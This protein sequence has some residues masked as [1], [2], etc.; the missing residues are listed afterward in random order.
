[1][2]DFYFAKGGTLPE[3]APSYIQRQADTDLYEAL[4]QAEYCYV[5]TS[6]QMGKSSLMVRVAERLRLDGAAVVV[7]EMTGIGTNLNVEQWYNG[8]LNKIGRNLGLNRQLRKFWQENKELGTLQRWIQAIRSVVLADSQQPLVICLDEIDVVL[9]LPFSTDEFFAGIRECYNNRTQDS[10]LQRL[11]F[12]L[13]GVATPSD[14]IADPQITPFNIGKRIDL[15]DF[16]EAEAA[17]FGQGLR[18]DKLL[19]RILYWT[20]GHP[21]LTQ[22]LC[23]LMVDDEMVVDKLCEEVFFSSRSRDAENNLQHVRSQVLDER[24]DTA[25]VLDL[26]RQVRS[27]KRVRDDDTNDLINTLRLAGL[28]HVK[29]NCLQVRN[30]IYSQVFDKVWIDGNMPDAEKRRQKSAFR[31]GLIQAGAVA[32]VLVGIA[33]YANEQRIV[34]EEQSK[35][36]QIQQ[37]LAEDE[38]QRSKQER[39]NSQLKAMS[40]TA[41]AMFDAHLEIEALIEIIK[42]GQQLK[43]K[44]LLGKI[45]SDTQITVATTLQKILYQIKQ[46]NRLEGHYGEITRLSFSPDGKYIVTSAVEGLSKGW[47]L[48]KIDGSL[49]RTLWPNT[50]SGGKSV[51][52]S[53]DG[54]IIALAGN[55]YVE[56]QT[57]D[58][59]LISLLDDGNPLIYDVE[60]SSDGKFLASTGGDIKIWRLADNKLIQ[61]LDF[62]ATD[63]V[64]SPN[65]RLFGASGGD[66][67]QIWSVENDTFK[68]IKKLV[69]KEYTEDDNWWSAIDISPDNQKF[70]SYNDPTS[71]KLWDN[72][73][74]LLKTFPKI[75][76]K[77]WTLDFSVDGQKIAAACSNNAL[78]K[79]FNLDG[80]VIDTLVGHRGTL[81]NAI[82]SPDG[83]F[84]AT[85]GFDATII[86]W[87]LN[88]SQLSKVEKNIPHETSTD[89][90]EI[91]LEE[92]IDADNYF[93]ENKQEIF[94]S[95]TNKIKVIV[96]YPRIVK[97]LSKDDKLIST[98]KGHFGHKEKSFNSFYPTDTGIDNVSFSPDEK[99]IISSSRGDTKLWK[100]DGTL[101]DSIQ[102]DNASFLPDGS[103]LSITID[104]KEVIWS[105]DID[106]LTKDG[107]EW[108]NNYLA[109]HPQELKSLKVCQNPS[110]LTRAAK[111]LAKEG[112]V[113]DAKNFFL[114]AIELNPELDIN[115]NYELRKL[116]IPV[117][118]E[119]ID[120]LQTENKIEK[121][122][123]KFQKIAELLNAKHTF[124][125]EED[126]YTNVAHLYENI[127]DTEKAEEMYA[128]SANNYN[129]IGSSLYMDNKYEQAMNAYEK[130]LNIFKSLKHNELISVVLGN[131][132]IVFRQL[133]NFQEAEK[134]YLGSIEILG[135]S[136]DKKSLA[137]NY[138]RL[139]NL[140]F[141]YEKLQQAENSYLQSAKLYESLDNKNEN[142]KESITDIYWSLGDLHLSIGNIQEAINFYHKSIKSTEKRY[143]IIDNIADKYIELGVIYYDVGDFNQAEQLYSK[144]LEIYKEGENKE[145]MA[146]VYN[147]LGMTYMAL[148]LQKEAENAYKS[149]IEF[150]EEL[151]K[152]G[153]TDELCKQGMAQ[154]YHNFGT[155]YSL[156]NNFLLAEKMYLRSIEINQEISNKSGIAETY[157]NLG[158][159]YSNYGNLQL[160]YIM[161]EKSIELWIESGNLDRSI[162]MQN[163]LNELK[164][165]E[166]Y[167]DLGNPSSTFTQ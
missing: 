147:E 10:D 6:R 7:L 24:K 12:C 38:S 140:Y 73:G 114:K 62:F 135:D 142:D 59:N 152:E 78:V 22:K 2:K 95:P 151:K 149:S 97:L 138:E 108:L 56:L 148:N 64:F 122:V 34:A 91:K 46:Y 26:Y 115:P 33:F 120:S 20:N 76:C 89:F 105:L 5:L 88:G 77:P 92:D 65:G 113:D 156:N 32:L 50:Q 42:I 117:L 39:D 83:K 25:A 134:M 61:T 100:I 40:N 48:W 63:I 130:S 161:L 44:A 86:L 18:D 54:K 14:L 36:A 155:F 45:E 166:N 66:S 41:E 75:D 109:T 164:N 4:K 68:T 101:I 102:G 123:S 167:D 137:I 143:H 31:R 154:T 79:I 21:Y 49:V 37:K 70:V 30:R 1:M 146:K 94:I 27:G 104:G 112:N 106:K 121:A 111:K 136:A 67:V 52:F 51:S 90:Q 71:I 13:I 118:I 153:K 116:V 57:I 160:A 129:D 17:L 126:V 103:G 119:Q 139:G 165:I 84:L 69:E 72:K 157:A 145:G 53:K 28:V 80:K 124:N 87:D 96:D 85:A 47:K 125:S 99:I 132:G 110:N 35:F 15:A 93:I 82:F 163:F 133:G 19:K 16:S 159:T 162:F 8:L 98:F 60:F 127:G 58:G 11:T 128:A 43:K 74:N 107:C 81:R 55:N 3:D 141:E 131:M 9:S 158:S 150:F 23:Q 144:S 29:G